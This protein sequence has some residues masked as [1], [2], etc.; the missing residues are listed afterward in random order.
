LN[1]TAITREGH[2][3]DVG[4]T[5]DE[6][7]NLRGLVARA[8]LHRDRA[9]PGEELVRSSADACIDLL[10]HVYLPKLREAAKIVDG[11]GF[12]AEVRSD[13]PIHISLTVRKD[14]DLPGDPVAGRLS[15]TCTREGVYFEEELPGFEDKAQRGLTSQPDAATRVIEFMKGALGRFGA[16]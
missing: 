5:E 6:V 16:Y 9:K 4:L 13:F 11:D 7:A 10:E 15:F 8:T 2:V 1:Y 14:S 12:V 3:K